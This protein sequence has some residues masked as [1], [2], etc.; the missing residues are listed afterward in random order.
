MPYNF[1]DGINST[2]QLIAKLEEKGCNHQ[3]YSFYC[4]EE[5]AENTIKNGLRLT[6]GKKWNDT[7]DYKNLLDEDVVRF[8]KCFTYSKS[9][10]IAMWMLYGGYN[11]DG[12]RIT[13][14]K[15]VIINLLNFKEPLIIYEIINNT[16]NKIQ[17]IDYKVKL[18]DIVYVDVDNQ[19]VTLK[20]SDNRKEYLGNSVDFNFSMDKYPW[21]IGV[22][23]SNVFD[24]F[25]NN[26]ETPVSYFRKMY[27]YATQWWN[28]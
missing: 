23:T 13:Y 22:T 10:N 5:K 17:I 25:N 6:V 26:L 14:D 3:T 9:E 15:K 12:I 21:S 20:K 27:T 24:Q 4:D 19:T 16:Q 11:N 1:F 2:G 28:K 18:I 8:V 7:N